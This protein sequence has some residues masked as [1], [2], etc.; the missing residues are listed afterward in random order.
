VFMDKT[1]AEF[2]MFLSTD[3]HDKM[4]LVSVPAATASCDTVHSDRGF[5]T[6]D[7]LPVNCHQHHQTH[8]HHHSRN[9]LHC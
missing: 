7:I 3:L 4:A 8:H 5:A 6:L 9:H 1:A 2:Y